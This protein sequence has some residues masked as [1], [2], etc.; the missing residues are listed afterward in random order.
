M[1]NGNFILKVTTDGQ[2]WSGTTSLTAMVLWF[3]VPPLLLF[4]LWLATRRA[5]VA[6]PQRDYI[7]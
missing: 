3:A 6:D 7:S 5:P 1:D 4:L 2:T